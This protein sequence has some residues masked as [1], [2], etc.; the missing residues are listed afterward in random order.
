[1]VWIMFSHWGLFRVSIDNLQSI[2]RPGTGVWC[3]DGPF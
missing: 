3:T 1:M 2:D